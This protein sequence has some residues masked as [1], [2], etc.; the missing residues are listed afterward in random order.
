M[1]KTHIK[2]DHGTRRRRVSTIGHCV[3]RAMGIGMYTQH[4]VRACAELSGGM[5]GLSENGIIAN[6][7]QNVSASNQSVSSCNVCKD[8]HYCSV[9]GKDQHYCSSDGKG[10]ALLQC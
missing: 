4:G 3:Y 1:R 2:D 6:R 5:P 9:G 8:Q 10:P 7:T